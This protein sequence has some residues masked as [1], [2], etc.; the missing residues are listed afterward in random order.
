MSYTL[1]YS[2]NKYQFGLWE[3]KKF[4]FKINFLDYF[5]FFKLAT[6]NWNREGEPIGKWFIEGISFIKDNVLRIHFFKF[7]ISYSDGT[8]RHFLGG[9]TVDNPFEE[10]I[11]MLYLIL[12]QVNISLIIFDFYHRLWWMKKEIINIS[13]IQSNHISAN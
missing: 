5:N 6:I 10:Y 4:C 7:G 3:K 12:P 1:N 13:E 2:F 8:N 11:H 9:D